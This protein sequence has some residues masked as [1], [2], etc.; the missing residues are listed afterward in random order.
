MCNFI[1]LGGSVHQVPFIQYI[2]RDYRICTLDNN[3]LNPGHEISSNYLNYSIL[4]KENLKRLYKDGKKF[5]SFGSDLAERI[6][7]EVINQKHCVRYLL[8]SKKSARKIISEVSKS[9]GIPFIKVVKEN[10]IND[11]SVIIKPNISS[12]SKGISVMTKFDENIFQKK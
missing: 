11:Q 1:Q 10:S 12:G 6:R 5:S 3:P 8:T 9:I 4:D 7:L 2:V